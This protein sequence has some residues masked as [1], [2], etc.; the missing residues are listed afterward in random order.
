MEAVRRTFVGYAS[1]TP[2]ER[3]AMRTLVHFYSYLG[4]AARFIGRYP[5][6]HPFRASVAAH[7]ADAERERLGALP[8]SYLS[9]IGLGGV[10]DAGHQRMLSLRPFDPFGDMADLLSVGGWLAAMNRVIATALQQVGVVRGEAELYPTMRYDP[11]TGR[12]KAVPPGF[13]SNL[14][15]NTVPPAGLVTAALGLNPKINELAQ[16]E[17]S[18]VTGA[19]LGT[20]GI[21]RLVRDVNV[22]EERFRGEVN[23][24]RATNDVRPEAMRSGGW[25]ETLRYPTLQD[26]Y[27]QLQQ[28]P[29]ST[30]A[31][32]VPKDPKAIAERVQGIV[33][34]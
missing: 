1:F 12:M 15:H 18:A 10:D 30:L 25:R 24:K 9:M 2:I 13:L 4:H 20:A 17:P 8:D 28:M 23:R 22:V 29:E 14:L 32:Y 11:E 19:L 33:G 3:Q 27:D 26:Y 34:G 5:L 16:R 31:D 6:D 7:I 21:P